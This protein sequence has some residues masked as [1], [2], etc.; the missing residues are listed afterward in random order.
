MFHVRTKMT[1]R[2]APNRGERPENY[3]W[4]TPCPHCGKI[5]KHAG[6]KRHIFEQKLR[7]AWLVQERK[8]V[9]RGVEPNETKHL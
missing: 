6:L 3:F 8:K 2:Y 4:S 9:G 1:R 5:F 7:E